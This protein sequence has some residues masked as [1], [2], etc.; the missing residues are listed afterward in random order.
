MLLC[1]PWN[2]LCRARWPQSHRDLSASVS[3]VLAL[4]ACVTISGDIVA[5]A[6]ALEP[7]AVPDTLSKT[8]H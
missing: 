7:G 6:W 3:P 2:S 8:C 1:L 4:K 5:T